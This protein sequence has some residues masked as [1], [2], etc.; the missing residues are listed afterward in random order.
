MRVQ[1]QQRRGVRGVQVVR[2]PRRFLR[3]LSMTQSR[4]A[5]KTSKQIRPV[6]KW[7]KHLSQTQRIA[8]FTGT[9]VVASATALGITA[10]RRVFLH[11]ETFEGIN[12]PG[13]EKGEHVEV[14]TEGAMET[15]EHMAS[16]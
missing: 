3:T 13:A 9:A 14:F 8:I 16:V 1:F 10:L 11:G 15:Q 2:V 4:M 12:A 7:W 5:G 6:Q